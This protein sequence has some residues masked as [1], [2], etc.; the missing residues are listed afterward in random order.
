MPPK[1][2]VGGPVLSKALKTN[3][4]SYSVKY[5]SSWNNVKVTELQSSQPPSS[6]SLGQSEHITFVECVIEEE[7]A[8]DMG[9]TLVGSS[10]KPAL[11]KESLQLESLLDDAQDVFTSHPRHG[12]VGASMHWISYTYI[13]LAGTK[14]NVAKLNWQ[15]ERHISSGDLQTP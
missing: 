7:W 12:W 5:A 6:T 13:W 4:Q 1:K 3:V 8:N 2:V 14:R 9:A 11:P 15:L 10:D